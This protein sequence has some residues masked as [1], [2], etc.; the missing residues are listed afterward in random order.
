MAD[1]QRSSAVTHAVKHGA[2]S[3]ATD[4]RRM[5]LLRKHEKELSVGNLIS[6]STW[7]RKMS[8]KV[9]A[10]TTPEDETLKII[11]PSAAPARGRGAFRHDSTLVVVRRA[12]RFRETR[13]RRYED[14]GGPNLAVTFFDSLNHH[15]G[16]IDPLGWFRLHWDIMVC[17]VLLLC[18]LVTPFQLCFIRHDIGC[19]EPLEVINL[20][21]DVIF[22][23]DFVLNFNTGYLDKRGARADVAT[24]RGRRQPFY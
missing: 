23:T 15:V 16:V 3:A 10:T 5:E 6:L 1:E 19:W 8:T 2:G 20:A 4:R 12:R 13:V 24:S 7:G 21:F 22:L 9:L 18:L 14:E 17:G 11:A